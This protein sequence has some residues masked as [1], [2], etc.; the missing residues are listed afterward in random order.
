MLSACNTSLGTAQLRM[1]PRRFRIDEL[2]QQGLRRFAYGGEKIGRVCFLL[3]VLLVSPS[4]L[5]LIKRNPI[6]V[7]FLSGHTGVDTSTRHRGLS[8][9]RQTQTKCMT[10]FC[11]AR[12]CFYNFNFSKRSNT[13][14][15][16]KRGLVTIG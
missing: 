14:N 7:I 6:Y 12:F 3:L 16:K 11:T 10:K 9:Q 13:T 1:K 5:Q 15:K 4:N 8:M 2:L